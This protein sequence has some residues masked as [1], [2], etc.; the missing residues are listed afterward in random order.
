MSYGVGCRCGS[1]LTWLWLWCRLA[2]TAQTRPLAWNL[3]YAMGA[4]QKKK[5][6]KKKKGMLLTKLYLG[7]L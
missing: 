1:D 6:K 7:Q 5:K 3:P 4:D 2:A